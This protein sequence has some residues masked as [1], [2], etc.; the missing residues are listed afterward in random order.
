M[1]ARR[2]L[3]NEKFSNSTR[4]VRL[5]C[6]SLQL[7]ECMTA[8]SVLTLQGRPPHAPPTCQSCICAHIC[9]ARCDVD[10]TSV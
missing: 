10:V 3:K 4:D 6:A 7:R 8:R 2:N 9:L 5:L 1:L